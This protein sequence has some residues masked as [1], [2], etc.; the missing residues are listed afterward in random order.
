MSLGNTRAVVSDDGER[1]TLDIYTAR[2]PQKLVEIEL[3]PLLA[4]SLVRHLVDAAARHM[5]RARL[6]EIAQPIARDTLERM[7]DGEA[8]PILCGERVTP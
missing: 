5:N 7:I 3:D 8:A 4:L 2:N 6:G 1:I